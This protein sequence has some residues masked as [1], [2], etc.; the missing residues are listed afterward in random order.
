MS[1]SPIIITLSHQ[2]GGVGKSTL[3]FNLAAYFQKQGDACAVVDSDLQGT[4]TEIYNNFSEDK[5]TISG[6]RLIRRNAFKDYRELLQLNQYA[7]I[8]VDTPPYLS[9]ELNQIY[10]ISD[11]VLVPTKPSVKDYLAISKTIQLIRM[12]KEANPSVEAGVVINMAVRSSKFNSIIREELEKED[13]RVLQTEIGQRVEFTRYE[14]YAGSIFDTN[15]EK[16]Q[17]EI[18]ALGKELFSILSNN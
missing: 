1:D 4:I 18:S 13:V 11:F 6:V 14:L 17:S 7:L 12:A 15:D 8:V 9:A 5:E 10:S 16:A 3:A 2:K